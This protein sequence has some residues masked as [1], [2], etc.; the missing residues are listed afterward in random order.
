MRVE[1]VLDQD[2]YNETRS[3]SASLCSRDALV[4]VHRLFH[5]QL[6]PLGVTQPIYRQALCTDTE[7]EACRQHVYPSS[8][9]VS[10]CVLCFLGSCSCICL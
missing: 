4:A 10:T 1:Y 3:Y 5:V 9:S 6:N 2:K 7:A 8:A